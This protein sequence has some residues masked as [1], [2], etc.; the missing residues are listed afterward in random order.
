[1]NPTGIAVGAG[2]VWVADGAANALVRLDPTTDRI[3]GSIPLGGLPKALVA[4]R[5]RVWV[6][7]DV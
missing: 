4:G 6:A 5:S 3:A 7:V 1:M 2:A